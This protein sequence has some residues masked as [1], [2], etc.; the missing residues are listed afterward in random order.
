M[1][2]SD[3]N[4]GRVIS[5]IGGYVVGGNYV[6]GLIV[7]LILIVVQFVVV[8]SGAQRVWWRPVSRWTACRVSR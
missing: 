8:T 2:L 3:A 7:F 5:A 4:A 1:I 6:I